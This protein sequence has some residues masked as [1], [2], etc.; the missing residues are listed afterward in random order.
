MRPLRPSFANKYANDN[1]ATKQLEQ[2]Q[3]QQSDALKEQA[4]H[5][6]QATTSLK[7]LGSGIGNVSEEAT[8]GVPEM[9]QFSGSIEK[10]LS[11]TAGGG[12]GLGLGGAGRL[13][14][15]FGFASGGLIN[16]DGTPTSDSNLALVSD[17]EHVVNAAATSKIRGLLEAINSGK[18]PKLSGS[19]QAAFLTHNAYSPTVNVHVEGR[20][21]R[22]QTAMK[23]ASHVNDAVNKSAR[24]FRYSTAQQHTMAPHAISKAGRKNG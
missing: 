6:T 12:G 11:S 4:E 13:A 7:G 2:A 21:G 5:A 8:Q 14:S 1:A 20:R 9:G 10:M 22:S 23:A 15:I 3:K 19:S 18:A 24:G 16:G 17:G